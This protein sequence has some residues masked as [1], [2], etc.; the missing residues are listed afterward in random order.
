MSTHLDNQSEQILEL[1]AQ[2]A[3]IS[4]KNKHSNCPIC[5]QIKKKNYMKGT[6]WLLTRS[7]QKRIKKELYYYKIT[8]QSRSFLVC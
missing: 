4:L 7:N 2:I 3:I 8:K 5:K 1:S 6:D